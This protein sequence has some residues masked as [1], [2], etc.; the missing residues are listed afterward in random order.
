M[1]RWIESGGSAIP[2]FTVGSRGL[3]TE[4]YQ[5]G[6]SQGWFLG[7]MDHDAKLTDAVT[8][9]YGFEKTDTTN[10]AHFSF[11]FN[12]Q[13][14]SLSAHAPWSD[15]IV[16]WDF[17]AGRITKSGLTFGANVY[18]TFAFTN[19]SARGMEIWFDGTVQT[20]GSH[21][22]R[23]VSGLQWQLGSG[24]LQRHYWHFLHKHQLPSSLIRQI[25][26][27]P[28]RTLVVPVNII[29]PGITFEAVSNA[30]LEEET[31][32]EDIT[33]SETLTKSVSK[34]LA[35]TES[36]TEDLDQTPSATNLADTATLFETLDTGISKRFDEDE[37]LSE[38][39]D[40]AIGKRFDETVTL[41]ESLVKDRTTGDTET[42]TEELDIT[43]GRTLSDTATMSEEFNIP[44]QMHEIVTPEEQLRRRVV[45]AFSES[46][47]PSDEVGQTKSLTLGDTITPGE[48]APDGATGIGDGDTYRTGPRLPRHRYFY[49]LRLTP[50][51]CI[52]SHVATSPAERPTKYN[53]LQPPGSA[54]GFVN[55]IYEGVVEATWV[56][57]ITDITG[58]RTIG[59][60][61]FQY[62]T[63]AGATFNGV[64]LTTS[65]S[66]V[67]LEQGME[68]SWDAAGVGVDF[69]LG[70]RWAFRTPVHY[71]VEAALDY[72][73]RNRG[74]S[75]GPATDDII[76]FDI[77]FGEP[78]L[79][80]SLIFMDHNLS[81]GAGV[82][83]VGNSSPSWGAPPVNVSIR[84]QPRQ[85]VDVFP[86]G[87]YQYWRIM[88]YD[89][90]NSVRIG[91]FYL[92]DYMELKYRP[93]SHL[94]WAKTHQ[95]MGSQGTGIRGYK[96]ESVESVHR[97]FPLKY[98]GLGTIDSDRLQL[99]RKTTWNVPTRLHRPLF[100]MPDHR[101]V[102]D[103]YLCYLTE[104]E[105][106][107]HHPI[108]GWKYDFTLK[109]VIKL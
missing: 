44:G 53:Q 69:A 83:V 26:A 9:M 20:T 52:P 5:A 101:V 87:T 78:T 92:G 29:V 95:R 60:A 74:Y 106:E 56:I 40:T 99:M 17:G 97:I 18:H 105:P 55:G 64:D 82:A 42:P 47:T 100:F 48:D 8:V 102:Q 32:N 51:N 24:D 77:D 30:V 27:D 71:G 34:G 39:L 61:K 98:D 46:T 63:D 23:T 94:P 36:P 3:G 88:I 33:P 65:T 50:Q 10:R 80:R 22:T 43:I 85:F 31:F 81:G 58:G 7:P 66:P 108:R 73:D 12:S 72:Q 11:Q 93:T 107:Q 89:P 62:S 104:F 68:F 70:D 76:T 54:L 90:T 86:G 79:V 13:A 6:L 15:G 19:G 57:E 25:S 45:K 109:S 38:N 49:D 2:R 75:A 41:S 21:S 28:Y 35:D 1:A 14:S 59:T 4:F 84:V 67:T 16:Y 96:R 37:T 91:K 103:F